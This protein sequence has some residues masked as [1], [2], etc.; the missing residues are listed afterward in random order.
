VLV[1]GV[2]VVEI[3]YDYK[4]VKC[5]ISSNCVGHVYFYRKVLWW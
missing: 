2:N 5:V 4:G 3:I 1:Y